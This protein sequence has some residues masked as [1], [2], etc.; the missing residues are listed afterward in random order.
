LY[1]SGAGKWINV[2]NP[3]GHVK[4]TYTTPGSTIQV[5]G[6]SKSG[7]GPF[8]VTYSIPSQTAPT[9]GITYTIAGDGNSGFNGTWI[10]ASSTTTSLTLQYPT[11]PGTY[12]ANP[13]IT[14]TGY[15]GKTGSGPYLV[16][17]NISVLVAPVNGQKY[18]VAGNSNAL[19]NGVYTVTSGSTS[20]V[21]LSYPSDP[22]TYGT[23]T[24]TF[25]LTTTTVRSGGLS[26]VLQPNVVVNSMVSET[27]A[28]VQSKLAMTAASTRP[29]ATSI[30]QADLGLASFNNTQF[31]AASGWISLVSSSS[32][33]NGVTL[34]KIQYVGSNSILGNLGGTAAIPSELTPGAVVTAGDGVK[35]ASFVG[36]GAMTVTYD[37]SN[38]TNNTYN[39]LAITTS[40]GNSSLVKT[41]SA[42]E[43]DTKQLK[44]DSYKIIDTTPAQLSVEYYTP[45]GY[46]Y[47]T[48]KGAD[49]SSTVAT[50]T[51]TLDVSSGTL[52]SRS[53]TT[54]AAATTGTITGAWALGSGSAIDATLGT[55]TAISITA[56]AEA[57]AGNLTGNWTMA[58]VSNLTFTSGSLTVSTGTVDVSG[59]TL[60]S[61]TLTTGA[62]GT[63]GTITGTWGLASGS[64]LTATYADLAE[65]YEGDQSYEAG[66][67]L[68][69]GG[70][71]EV[72]TTTTMSDTR[73]AG[74]V[75]TNPAYV[76]NGGQ[77]GIKVCI[78][79]AGRV[80]VKVIGRVKKGDMLTT[81][82]TAGYAVKANDPKLGSIIGK[83][84]EDKDNGEAGVIQVAIGRV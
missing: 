75:T 65:F 11:D 48:V 72:T 12:T 61:R 7:T 70:D 37:G 10:A 26:T 42:G 1:D 46:N 80:P 82:A 38:T 40:G 9:T 83:A 31:T 2:A 36:T 53:L 35:N 34:N 27:A 21:Q 32:S 41:G 6:A 18:V 79:L 22:G 44:V 81:S 14:S 73:S 84:L 45:G 67:V 64:T 49:G 56:G 68:V 17:F 16:T 55:I 57:T 15:N 51:G 47:L 52:K 3:T 19:Y 4:V 28:I 54:G 58:G 60:R 25:V 20:T 24:T 66:T 8:L 77:T 69:F 63:T 76:M 78:A 30:T 39:Y 33:S 29:N 74:V 62:T 43:I 5:T 23:G 71:K 13:T 59:G 50:Q